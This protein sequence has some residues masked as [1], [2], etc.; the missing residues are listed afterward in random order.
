MNNGIYNYLK[1]TY[2]T[3]NNINIYFKI[4]N[5]SFHKQTI[6]LDCINGKNET[7]QLEQNAKY[8]GYITRKNKN[9]IFV[10]IGHCFNWE[11]GAITAIITK[12]NCLNSKFQSLTLGNTIDIYCTKF[13]KN[14][15]TEF[16][17]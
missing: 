13:N 3:N 1:T 6:Y 9:C 10:E 14:E 2:N 17:V 12:Q 4:Q 7:V 5:I 15:C 11:Y 8:S 16:F